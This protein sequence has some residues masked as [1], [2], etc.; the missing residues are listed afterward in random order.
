[1]PRYYAVVKNNYIQQDTRTGQLEIYE[2]ERQANISRPASCTV[3]PVKVKKK[4]QQLIC[5]PVDNTKPDWWED[6]DYTPYEN[7]DYERT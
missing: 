3:I 7:S 5:G 1:M 4:K 2:T 6:D